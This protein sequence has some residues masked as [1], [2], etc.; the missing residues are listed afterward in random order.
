MS[1]DVRFILGSLGGLLLAM[2]GFFYWLVRLLIHDAVLKSEL[3]L[4]EKLAK[5]EARQAR[6]EVRLV[7]MVR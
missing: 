3:A 6:L 7:R 1:E 2:G 5:L 4:L